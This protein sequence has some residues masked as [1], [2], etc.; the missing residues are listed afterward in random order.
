M[1]Q[2]SLNR[3]GGVDLEDCPGS[4]NLAIALATYFSGHIDRPDPDPDT[5]DGWGEWVLAK[6]NEA[7][8]RIAEE[9]E[10]P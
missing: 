1:N 3:I 7:L 10:K 9:V 6:T 2:T 4:D 5:E 8:R